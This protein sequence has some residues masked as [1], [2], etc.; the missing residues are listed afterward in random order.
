MLALES[1][2]MHGMATTHHCLPMA[3]QGLE[4]HGLLLAMGQTK[5]DMQ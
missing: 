2:T 3:K 5:V 4:S 1:L